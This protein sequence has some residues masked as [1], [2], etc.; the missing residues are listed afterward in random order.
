MLKATWE[1][2]KILALIV[3]IVFSATFHYQFGNKRYPTCDESYGGFYCQL[4]YT[5]D[6]LKGL[7]G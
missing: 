1:S 7:V 4:L 6:A 2:S 3:L 5:W